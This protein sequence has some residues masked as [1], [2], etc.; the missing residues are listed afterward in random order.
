MNQFLKEIEEQPVALTETLRYYQSNQGTEC[1]KRIVA[2]WRTGKFQK[3]V[4]TGMG[5]SCF[6]AHAASGLL[7][8]SN[9]TSFAV[10]AGEMLHYQSSLLGSSSLLVCISQSGES[11]EIVKML[12]KVPSF[13]P[14]IAVTN[15]PES[16]LAKH[17][18]EVL[19]SK[20]GKEEMTST[21]TYVSTYLAAY[22][23]SLALTGKLNKSAY[24]S[25][26]I[27]IDGVSGLLANRN[28]WL[29]K[30]VEIIAHAPFVQLIGRG[31]VFATAQQSA[32][33]MMEATRNPASALLGGEFRHGPMEMIKSGS[34]VVIF[35]PYGKTYKQS[36]TAARDVLAFEANVLLVTDHPAVLS[37]E[38]LL[39][40]EIPA[41]NEAL[42]AITSVIPIQLIVN[43]WSLEEENV[44]GNFT[45]GAKITAIE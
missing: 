43:Q 26:Q 30:A 16:T 12:E 35:A 31:P 13:I 39:T 44:P 1:L 5:S 28:T 45:R 38:H 6:I 41:V 21:K 24:T 18:H 40:I 3:I 27:T 36:I 29:S 37:H 33:M 15:E 22:I 4:F 25:V 11:Y 34:R 10:N 19:L 2:L 7:N 32:L 23:L 14:V 20:A 8:N 42:F 9:I 17:A